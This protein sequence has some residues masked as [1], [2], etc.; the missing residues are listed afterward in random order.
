MH[1]IHVIVLQTHIIWIYNLYGL[2]YISWI[3]IVSTKSRRIPTQKDDTRVLRIF[4][5]TIRYKT[6]NLFLNLEEK[7][8][9]VELNRK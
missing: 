5:T 3:Q 9:W 4:E 6:N 8:D 2:R 7:Q 1:T